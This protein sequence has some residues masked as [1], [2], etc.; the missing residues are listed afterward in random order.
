MGWQ[1]YAV[2]IV[3]RTGGPSCLLSCLFKGFGKEGVIQSC[4]FCQPPEGFVRAGFS[5]LSRG[6]INCLMRLRV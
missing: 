6:R 1:L 5:L 4:Q 2:A 3:L